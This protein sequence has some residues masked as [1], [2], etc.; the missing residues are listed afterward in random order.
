MRKVQWTNSLPFK[1][2]TTIQKHTIRT[3]THKHDSLHCIRYTC[4][5]LKTKKKKL[6]GV[7]VSLERFS[8][9]VLWWVW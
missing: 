7:L 4:N 9:T 2:K 5:K 1:I 8:N 3:K 6:S